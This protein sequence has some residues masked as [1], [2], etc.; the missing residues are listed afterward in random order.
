MRLDALPLTVNGKLDI[1][2]LP[3]PEYTDSDRYRPRPPH[4]RDPGRHLRPGPR[5][6]PGRR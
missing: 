3:A 6:R 1:R 4:R 5:R 2:A